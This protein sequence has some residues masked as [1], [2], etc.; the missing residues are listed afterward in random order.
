MKLIRADLYDLEE[1]HIHIFGD[2]HIGSAKYDGKVVQDRIN[3]VL[4]DPN[5]RVILLG[6]L[7]NN[8]TKTSV[9]DCYSEPLSPMEQIKLA[10]Q[11][12][13]PIKDRVIAIVS[14]NHERRSY[15]T[16]GIDLTYFLATEL[17]IADRYNYTACCVI[18]RYAKTERASK[19]AT[20]Y[21]THGDGN[22]G[23]L[24]GGKANGMSK[25]GQIINADI[26]VTGHT[27]TPI[28]FS[29]ASYE[30]DERHNTIQLHEQLFVN[31]GATLEYEEYAEIYGMRPSCKRHPVITIKD[32]MYT[33]V[34]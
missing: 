32:N 23:K 20:I 17:G 28:V 30:I 12:L 27:H 1:V 7:I 2:L 11:I 3:E 18:V 6:D 9:G 10:S 22:G 21:C 19:V 24:V 26:I 33:A 31:C 15:K 29:E 34:M 16:D 4:A 13:E 14:G 5:A 8:S 25:R